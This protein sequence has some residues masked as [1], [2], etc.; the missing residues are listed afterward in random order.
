M[1]AKHSPWGGEAGA[2]EPGG[3][4][5]VRAALVEGEAVHGPVSCRRSLLQSLSAFASHRPDIGS[6]AIGEPPNRLQ[7][8]GYRWAASLRDGVLWGAESRWSVCEAL[9]LMLWSDAPKNHPVSCA[10]S[11][12]RPSPRVE[13]VNTQG[14]VAGNAAAAAHPLHRG[15]AAAAARR[16]GGGRG[17]G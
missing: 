3:Q 5:V 12:Q 2:A 6:A 11:T 1:L 8:T 10:L 13:A 17:R 9:M 4:L 14:P 15:E 16:A 7:T